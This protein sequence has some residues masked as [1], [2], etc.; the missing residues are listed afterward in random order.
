MPKLKGRWIT[1]WNRQG[2][3]PNS[4]SQS[5]PY[6]HFKDARSSLDK[7][8]GNWLKDIPDQKKR[9]NLRRIRVEVRTHRAGDGDLLLKEPSIEMEFFIRR[10]P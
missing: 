8:L 3:Q 4:D 2:E 9:A 6:D 10:V 1:G 7:T 5:G